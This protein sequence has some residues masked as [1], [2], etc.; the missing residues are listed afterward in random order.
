MRL[1]YDPKE[2]DAHF[3]SID[4][5]N[6]FADCDQIS[7]KYLAEHGPQKMTSYAFEIL[8]S[9]KDIE[10]YVSISDVKDFTTCADKFARWAAYVREDDDRTSFKSMFYLAVLL[11]LDEDYELLHKHLEEDSE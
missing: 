8:C 1:A 7:Q 2:D 4:Y 10:T 9:E 11:E 3:I 5:D 6:V